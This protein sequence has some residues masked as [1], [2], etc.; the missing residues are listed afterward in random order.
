MQSIGPLSGYK[1][2]CCYCFTMTDCS[3]NSYHSNYTSDQ[4][5][6]VTHEIKEEFGER[7]YS[8]GLTI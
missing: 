5:Q 2:G 7:F 6:I 8:A 3:T 1:D 4:S